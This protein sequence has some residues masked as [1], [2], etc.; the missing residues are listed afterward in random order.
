MVEEEVEG[1]QDDHQG[2]E[3]LAAHI[4]GRH[5]IDRKGNTNAPIFNP[6][7][8]ITCPE[9]SLIVRVYTL[10]INIV[11]SLMIS[12]SP[13]CHMDSIELQ[14]LLVLNNKIF[15]NYFSR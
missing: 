6:Q 11:I 12:C 1:D 4:I 8:L 9:V 2:P 13:V 3:K 14:I 7:L 10:D 15:E 5:M